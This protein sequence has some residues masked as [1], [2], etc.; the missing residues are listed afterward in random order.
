MSGDNHRPMYGESGYQRI[1]GDAYWTPEWCVDVLMRHV[2][3]LN[4]SCRQTLEPA[5]GAGNISRALERHKISVVS[6]DINDYGFGIT[7]PEFNFLTRGIEDRICAIITNPPYENSDAFVERAIQVMRP[8]DGFVAMLLRNE[9]DAAASRSRLL[10]RLSLKLV[11]TKRPRWSAD[12][13]ASPRHNFA[14]F[15]WDFSSNSEPKIRW[16]Q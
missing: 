14:W 10:A 2:T 16:D 7:G 12:N 5:C 11:L 8:R 13:K 4:Q 15:C 6:N 9:W 3:W 1:A